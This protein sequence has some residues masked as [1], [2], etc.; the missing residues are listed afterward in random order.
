V[1]IGDDATAAGMALVP[2][3]GDGGQVRL[4]AQEINRT[5]DY[6]A[7]VKA[8]IKGTWPVSNGGT[9]GTDTP[10]ARANLGISSGTAAPSDSVGGSNDGNIYFQIVSS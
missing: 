6:I 2:D 7:Q 10:T 3:T 4:G 1:A 8:L 5:R 9:G